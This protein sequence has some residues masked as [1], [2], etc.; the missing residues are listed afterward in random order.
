[1]GAKE[2]ERLTLNKNEKKTKKWEI[3]IDPPSKY[4]KMKQSSNSNH[5]IL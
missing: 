2:S 3:K 1:L 4:A 5:I